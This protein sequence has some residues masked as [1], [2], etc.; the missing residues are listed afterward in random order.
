MADSS[1]FRSRIRDDEVPAIDL[2]NVQSN[3]SIDAIIGKVSDEPQPI[4]LE[5]ARAAKFASKGVF[6]YWFIA[7]TII[8]FVVTEF[9]T[10]IM[11]L[12]RRTTTAWISCATHGF[13][14]DRRGCA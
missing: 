5:S 8:P 2:G 3:S 14:R 6:S 11:I 7:D 10:E 4:P 12:E 13:D 9:L 1:I